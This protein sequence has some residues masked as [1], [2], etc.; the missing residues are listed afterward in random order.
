MLRPARIVIA[1]ITTILF[2]GP[3]TAETTSGTTPSGLF[4]EASGTGA[5]LVFIHAFSVDRRM[6]DAQVTAFEEQ[7]R[8][9]RYDLR[10]HGRSAAPATPYAA[11]E[12][13]RDV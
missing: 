10:G 5:P 8:L 3:A 4:Y 6:W 2:A 1:T 9:I 13:L 7:H 11:Y 12:D